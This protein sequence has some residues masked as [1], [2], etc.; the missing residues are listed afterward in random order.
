MAEILDE[1]QRAEWWLFTTANPVGVDM[2]T[3]EAADARALAELPENLR[4]LLWS[5]KTSARIYLLGQDLTLSDEQI[6]H[7]ARLVRRIILGEVSS[8]NLEQTL[9]NNLGI[10]SEKAARIATQLTKNLIAPNYFQIAQTYEKKH[11][12][13]GEKTPSPVPPPRAV[14]SATPTPSLA[15]PSPTPPRVVDLR[16]GNIPSRLPPPPAPMEE[17]LG[18][19]LHATPETRPLEPPP[20][21]RLP[22]PPA[23]PTARPGPTIPPPKAPP[24]PAPFPRPLGGTHG[25]IPTSPSTP[26]RTV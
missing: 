21:P 25:P 1:T 7:I 5:D 9:S 8:A 26:P 14:P 4:E 13:Q 18:G 12:T 20:G 17:V 3:P 23:L 24:A 16:N 15:P 2:G 19:T 10:P 22:P 6:A 11:R